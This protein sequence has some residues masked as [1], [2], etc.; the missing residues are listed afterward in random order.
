MPFE[1]HWLRPLWLLLLPL[2]LVCLYLCWHLRQPASPWQQLLPP[3]LQ[4][5][6][7]KQQLLQQQSRTPY[8][9]LL[10]AMCLSVVALAG[11]SVQKLPQPAFALNKATV[12]V[13]D[14]SMSMLATDVKPN[15]LTQARFKALDFASQLQE[16]ELALLTFAADA[17]VISPLTP[18]HNNIR[19]LLPDLT[20][21]IMPAQG[22]NLQSA[23]ELA[24]QL[25]KQAGYP[26]GDVV[27]MSDGFSASHYQQLRQSLN[28]YPH[29]ISVLAF[30]SAEGAPVRLSSGEL[31]KDR[32]GSIVIPKVPLTQLKDIAQLTGGVFRQSSFDQADIQALLS[33]PPLSLAAEKDVQSSKI[34]GDQWQDAGVYLCWLL[35]PLALWLGKRASILVV[36]PLLL[37][38]PESKAVEWRDLWQT[39]QQQAKAAYADKDYAKAL[40]KFEQPLWQGN[41]AYRSGDYQAAEQLFRQDNSA[42]GRYNLG[43]SLMQQQ[44]FEDALQAYQEAEKLQPD[45]AGL[46]QNIELAKQLLQQQQQQQNSQKDGEQQ[47]SEQQNSNQNSEQ[48]N[49]NQN[50]E[51][52][53]ENGQ[54]QEQQNEKS[55]SESQQQNGQNGEGKDPE[56]Q[57]QQQ[58]Q[59][60]ANTD[61]KPAEQQQA[62]QQPLNEQDKEQQKAVRE[63]WPNAS[64]EQ[65]QQLDGLMRKVQDDPALLLRNKMLLEYQKRQ[66]QRLPKGAEQ[67]W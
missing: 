28:N 67:E 6:L 57:N 52:Q 27:V 17:Y 51:Q 42:A 36:L 66:Q 35:L 41:A 26:K 61:K 11:P 45:L 4:L 55:D 64:P 32:N 53:S 22:S 39:P 30:G 58:Q 48:Q 3:H 16:G 40:E 62:E 21:E 54:K 5:R 29:R 31:L 25:L 47:N 24:A 15:R 59:E 43:N 49:A 56:P 8:L 33:Q 50:S 10:V 63:A 34:S 46:A 12:L 9:W 18:D 20:P 19:L 44:K 7:L 23:L 37:L 60:K 65:S 1:L 38:S 14:M 13:L 2:V